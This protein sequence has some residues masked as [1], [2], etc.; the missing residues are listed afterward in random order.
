MGMDVSATPACLKRRSVQPFCTA[1]GRV[2][3]GMPG[4]VLS[5]KNCSL[6]WIDLDSHLIHGCLGPPESTPQTA[7]RSVQPFLH[8][9]QTV[10]EHVGACPS[11]KNCPF[12]WGSGPHL[13]HSS[14]GPPDSVPQTASRSV[15]P[16]FHSSLQSVSVLFNGSTLPLKI[17]PSNGDLDTI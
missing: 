6:V 4:H 2:S 5:H 13:I 8:S 17:A 10:I 14:F 1:H 11:R 7:S 12:P 15:Q 3:P 16:F 9:S